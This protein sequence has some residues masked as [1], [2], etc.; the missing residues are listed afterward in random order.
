M[1]NHR[2][3][4]RASLCFGTNLFCTRTCKR[5]AGLFLLF[6]ANQPANVAIVSSS[7]ERSHLLLRLEKVKFIFLTF[8][9]HLGIYP[10]QVLQICSLK[11][12]QR[13]L[14]I[15]VVVGDNNWSIKAIFA[16]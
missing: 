7:P 11:T 4:N 12:F 5:S 3:L 9:V 6:S 8:V 13:S 14:V 1:R 15:R 10:Y 16:E 2:I